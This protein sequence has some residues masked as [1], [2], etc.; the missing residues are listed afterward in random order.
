[1]KKIFITFSFS[2]FHLFCLAQNPALYNNGNTLQINSGATLYINGAFVNQSTS[3]YIN[4]GNVAVIGN[5]TNNQAMVSPFAGVLVFDGTSQQTVSGSSPLLA[6][7]VEINNATGVILNNTLQISGEC[8]FISGIVSTSASSTPMLFTSAGTVSVTNPASNTSHVR[9]YVVK[10]GT[11]NFAYPVGDGT[12]YQ[13]VDVNLSANSSGMRVTYDTTN[14]GS[15][16][17]STG[18]SE[19]TALVAYNPL[20]FWDISPI[21]TAT[22]TVTIYW[23]NYRNVGIANVSD[24][25]VAHK[26]GGNWLNE[27]TTGSGTIAA[28][29]VTSNSL[30]SWSPFGLGSISASSPLPLHLLQFSGIAYPTYNQL[31]WQ[32]ANEKDISS[33]EL[34][35]SED[36]KN[37]Q[38]IGY[39]AAQESM[40]NNYHYN[41]Y[42]EQ[43][44]NLF[45][46]L[47][48]IG[49][50][51]ETAYSNT[52][53]INRAADKN[54]LSYVFPNPAQETIYLS[55]SA[56]ALIG[57]KAQLFDIQG[58]LIQ[59][60]LINAKTLSIKLSSLA[61]GTYILKLENG[62]VFHIA[63][64][65]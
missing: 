52:L 3:N 48:M 10:E 42:I 32:T 65:N 47:K 8:S 26:S 1:M 51:N 25:K 63:K 53:K 45:Y 43:A 57:S 27:G 14:A 12:R 55:T 59:E 41:D 33:F 58:K 6:Q 64:S 44:G 54:Q 15:A 31:K 34:Q 30:S 50:E 5:M 28:G 21:G 24:L 38:T 36:G 62:E 19:A 60:T 61:Q 4:N 35:R 18:G 20:E 56:E 13:T 16:T 2:C 9:G 22:G 37:Y 17:F 7:D 40:N 11:G 23:D 49:L 46:R 29:S 39:I